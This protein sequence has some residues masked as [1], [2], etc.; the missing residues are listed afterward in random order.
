MLDQIYLKPRQQELLAALVAADQQVEGEDFQL[1]E[2]NEAT[3]VCH[4]G[5]PGNYIE[6]LP[7]DIQ[8]LKDAK[9][10]RFQGK[11]VFAVTGLAIKYLE[12]IQILPLATPS[13]GGDV[14]GKNKVFGDVVGG[15]KFEAQ[16]ITINFNSSAQ[17]LAHTTDEEISEHHLIVETVARLA[18]AEDKWVQ[19]ADIAAALSI[20]EDVLIDHIDMLEQAGKLQRSPFQNSSDNS[21]CLDAPGRLAIN[22][23]T[24]DELRQVFAVIT[25]R[26]PTKDH[27]LPFLS[28]CDE[29]AL[30]HERVYDLVVALEQA[31][32]VVFDQQ[33][34]PARIRIT[35]KGRMTAREQ[36]LLS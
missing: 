11:S 6:C 13:V 2:T 29:L 19:I 12:N 15:S 32:L 16:N 34:M 5:L 14:V 3:I 21:V 20:N 31:E 33:Q 24:T 27:F 4:R 22:P 36:G 17:P 8:A 10:V 9:L 18:T 28:L 35:T 30:G 26:A 25:H 23:P 1:L 7:A